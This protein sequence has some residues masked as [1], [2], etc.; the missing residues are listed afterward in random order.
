VAEIVLRGVEKEYETSERR[1][2]ALAGV[3]L[4]VAEREFVA[5]VG[6]SGCGKTTLLNL[7][8]GFEHPTRGDVTVDGKP[9]SAPGP[10]RGVVFQH[11]ALFPWLT[12]RENV[13]FGLRLAANRHRQVPPERIDDMIRKVGLERFANALPAQLSG[14]MRQRAAIASVLIIDPAVLLMD[15]PFGALDALTRSVMQDFVLQL[16]EDN[17]K[18]VVLVT[19]DITEAIYLSD[20]VVVMT[21]HPGTIH[22]V[23]PVKLSRPRTLDVQST[24]QFNEIREHVTRMLRVETAA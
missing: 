24:P 23:I 14:G 2:P 3:D 11:S 4:S 22:E 16:W 15:E 8:A 7:V 5:I 10:D 13:A 21:S 12:V 19:H 20:R 1:I 18:T 6:A 9:V 17:R